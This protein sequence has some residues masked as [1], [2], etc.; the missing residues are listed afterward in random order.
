VYDVRGA[1]VALLVNEML[2]PGIYERELSGSTLEPGIYW[3]RLQAGSLSETRKMIH[4][5]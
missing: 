2:A 4:V 3:S 1:E 5:R